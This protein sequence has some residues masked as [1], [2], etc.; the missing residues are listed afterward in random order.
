MLLD[1]S[2]L[3]LYHNQPM[4][5][6]HET[7]HP[8]SFFGETYHWFTCSVYGCNQCYDMGNGYYV[9]REGAI[10]DAT[11]KQPCTHCGLFLYLTK[12]GATMADAVWLCSNEECPSNERNGS[13]VGQ[14]FQ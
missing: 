12:S 5:L 8:I 14:N 13:L 9:M 7:L 1:I 3:C 4:I 11:N 10:E 2:P 6:T